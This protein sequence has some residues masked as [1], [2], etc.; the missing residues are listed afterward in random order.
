MSQK[1]HDT[2]ELRQ[3]GVLIALLSVYCKYMRDFNE[4]K[5]IVEDL[6]KKPNLVRILS[7]LFNRDKESLS[8]NRRD[9]AG[10]MQYLGWA[11]A[12]FDCDIENFEKIYE[13]DFNGKGFRIPAPSEFVDSNP[14][15]KILPFRFREA[16]EEE[17]QISKEDI[18]ELLRFFR[19]RMEH[20]L[21]SSRDMQT[22]GFP[23]TDS[24]I[25]E[26]SE[27]YRF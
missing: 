15:W 20:P 19:E 22:H 18:A 9:F 27:Q 3:H 4:N 5:V 21:P 14:D 11:L 10:L 23:I 16:A 13:E 12:R 8:N 2:P 1:L 6:T 24:W 7:V 25:D 17:R 26:L